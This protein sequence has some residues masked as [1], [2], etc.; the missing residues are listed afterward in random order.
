VGAHTLI[1]ALIGWARRAAV[2]REARNRERATRRAHAVALAGERTRITDDL[3]HVVTRALQ[4]LVVRAEGI[5]SRIGDPAVGPMAAMT[6][7]QAEARGVLAAMRR[8][9]IVLRHG[10]P[11]TAEGIA[12]PPRSTPT[13]VR[14]LPAPTVGGVGMTVAGSSPSTW[15][16][17]PWVHLAGDSAPDPVVEHLFVVHPDRPWVVLLL[18]G[19]LVP[20]GW[21][22]TP[23][24][25]PRS[26]WP[27]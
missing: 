5:R 20:L 3:D 8:V 21:W 4:Q 2:E 24:R 14:E 10:R 26:P 18:A 22:R 17:P 6:E 23:R 9:L 11:S 12:V 27:P 1:A 25:S 19:Q 13:R 7:L 16:V 15:R